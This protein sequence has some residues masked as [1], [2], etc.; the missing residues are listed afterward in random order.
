MAFTRY[1]FSLVAAA[2][3]VL[4]I[5]GLSSHRQGISTSLPHAATR[6]LDF[7]RS[8]PSFYEQALETVPDKVTGHKYQH[9]YQKYLPA[10]RNRRIK[11]LQIG[12]GCD[13][14]SG[15]GG[16]YHLW[17]EYFANIDLHFIEKDA[18]CTKKYRAKTTGATIHTDSTFLE[19]LVKD[20]G[21]DFDI[22]IDTGEH[23]MVQQR[24]SFYRLFKALAP[25]E[26]YFCEGLQTSFDEQYGGGELA[27]QENA[28][29]MMSIGEMIWDMSRADKHEVLEEA[30][31]LLS[32]YCMAE[33]CAFWKLGSGD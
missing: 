22:I 5:A 17:L 7:G 13:M 2:A 9:M 20:T 12:L 27:S 30:G 11:M 14:D 32:V 23:S 1:T 19:S 28:S 31:E 33:I 21:G 25:G 29:M 24:T 26:V 8:K 4:L 16:I 6:L 3:I 18:A 15:P 10:L